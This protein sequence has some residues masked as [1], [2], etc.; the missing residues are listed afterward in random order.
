MTIFTRPLCL[1]L[2]VL[3]SVLPASAQTRIRYLLTSPT[4][5]V[6][7]AAHSS[8][9]EKLGFWKESGLDVDSSSDPGA[10]AHPSDRSHHPDLYRN[11]ERVEVAAQGCDEYAAD[12]AD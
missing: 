7:E 6:A 12:D 4:P 8:V 9:P 11:L 2:F 3:V 5:N 1:V 10:E